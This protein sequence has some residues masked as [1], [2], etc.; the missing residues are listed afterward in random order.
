MTLENTRPRDLRAHMR[1]LYNPRTGRYLH[2][3]GSGETKGT[4]H[5]WAG[6]R[7]Q[8]EVLRERARITGADFPFFI[9]PLSGPME[10]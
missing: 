9:T 6:T 1:R 2:L 8:A 5:A 7:D 4:A 10:D 3:S